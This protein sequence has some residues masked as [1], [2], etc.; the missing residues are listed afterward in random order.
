MSEITQ[1]PA[2]PAQYVDRAADR[3]T[4]ERLLDSQAA[5]V[6]IYGLPGMGKTALAASLAQSVPAGLALDTVL[7]ADLGQAADPV[8]VLRGW[9][10]HLQAEVTAVTGTPKEQLAYLRGRLREAV[11]GQYVLFVLDDVGSSKRDI[12]AASACL[13]DDSNCRYL[14]TTVSA[15]T[16][17]VFRTDRSF[18][19]YHVEELRDP[20]AGQVLERYAEEMLSLAALSKAERERLL[21]LGNGLPLGLMVLGRFLGQGLVRGNGLRSLLRKLDAAEV[22]VQQDEFGAKLRAHPERD[23]IH[24]ILTARWEDLPPD[25]KEALQTA[26]VFRDKP[27]AFGEAAWACILQARRVS[28]EGPEV[29]EE[30]AQRLGARLAKAELETG[31][32]LDIF[33]LEPGNDKDDLRLV[34]KACERL[35]PLRSALLDTGL[36]EQPVLDDPSFALHSLIAAFLRIIPG[37]EASEQERVHGLAARYY[38]GWLA[39][40][41]EDHALVSPYT[42]AYRFENRQWLG[43]TLDLCYH[44]R[45]DGREVSEDEAVVLLATLFFDAFWWWGELVPYPLCDELLRMWQLA[46]LGPKATKCLEQ[47]RKFYDN[48]PVID[49][50]RVKPDD[51]KALPSGYQDGTQVAHFRAVR[52]AVQSVRAQV[53][54]GAANDAAAERDR[55]RLRMLTVVYL[56]EANRVTG[57]FEQADTDFREALDLLEKLALGHND[58]DEQ[59]TDDQDTHDQGTDDSAAGDSAEED[60]DDSDDWI[61]PYVHSEVADLYVRAGDPAK[62]LDACDQ[63][64]QAAVGDGE[65]LE[66]LNNEDADHEVFGWLWMAA[67]GA[68]WQAGRLPEAWRSYAWACFHACT[69]ELWPERVVLYGRPGRIP[70]RVREFCVDD[71]TVVCY[72]LSLAKML[73]RLGELW[74]AGRRAEA[75]DGVRVIRETLAGGPDQPG[76]DPGGRGRLDELAAVRPETSWNDCR[77]LAWQDTGLAGLALPLIPW[78][79]LVDADGRVDDDRIENQRSA[80]SDLMN[81]LTGI[82]SSSRWAPG[83]GPGQR[84]LPLEANAT[85]A[86]EST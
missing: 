58:G 63:G 49:L 84:G 77:D 32:P 85:G 29:P 62:A 75:C 73:G 6:A 83:D 47:L 23:S 57:Q 1:I 4:I 43:A 72:K 14:L 40:Y 24:T 41:Q 45:E 69:F 71:Y 11:S 86:A 38:R 5:R 19:T 25:Q 33:S 53:L 61:I 56:G 27:H 8:D 44:L 74:M 2:L 13:I 17:H 10:Q 48:Y 82:W 34:M 30:L 35:E 50:E 36:M 20:E 65:V 15:Q 55:E 60:R 51:P 78:E 54:D 79:R 68:Y 52:D 21:R 66:D 31:E 59:H 37:F 42:A 12:E 39:G 46:H 28:P 3:R 9:C 26:A 18:S 70:E 7:W 67:G 16:A 76:T 64:T 81:R 80:A 22:L